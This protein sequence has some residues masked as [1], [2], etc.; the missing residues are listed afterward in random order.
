MRKHLLFAFIANVFFC[1]FSV[2]AQT[3][4]PLKLQYDFP[5]TLWESEALP[6]GNGNIGA[7]VFGDVPTDIIQINEHSLWSGGPGKNPNY[8]GGHLQTPE[9][10]TKNLLRAQEAL[11]KDMTAFSATKQAYID[12]SGKVVAQN[13]PD[14]ATTRAY[15]N[16]LKGTKNDFGSYQSLGNINIAYTS[17]VIPEILNITGDCDNPIGGEKLTLLFDGSIN[18]KWY[19]DTGFKKFPCYV[20]WEYASPFATSAYTLTSGNDVPDRDP[21]SWNLYGSNDGQEYTLID[22][23]SNITFSGRNQS[24]RYALSSTVIYKY[25]KFEILATAGS[26]GTTPPQLSEIALENAA[27]T[28]FPA[29][30]NY[31]RELDIDRSVA[32]V[33][34]TQAGVNYTREYFISH[35]NNVLV[36]RLTADQ[37]GKLS[38]NIWL[39]T[40]QTKVSISASAPEGT[41]TYGTVAITGQ[42]SD[43]TANGLKFA[44]E[45]QV[46]APNGTLSASNDKLTVENADEILII[47]SAATNYFWCMDDTYNYFSTEDPLTKAEVS[48]GK[49]SS[50]AYSEILDKHIQDYQSLFNRMSLSLTNAANTNGKMTDK[51]LAGYKNGTNTTS[52]NLYLEELYFQYGRYL[53]ISS[54]RKGSLPA[55]LQGIWAEGLTPP[56][57]AD[58]HTNINIQMNYWLAEQTNLADCH[59]PAIDYV[60]S[61]VPRG[62]FTAKRYF[63]EKTRGW[64]DFHENN[65]WGNTGPATSDAFYFPAAAGWLC[66]DIWEYYL[67][68]QDKEFLAEY[69][70]VMLDAALFWVDNLWTDTRDGTLVASPSYSPEHGPYAIGTACDQGVIT[71]LFDM[72]IKA[73]YAITSQ[74]VDAVPTDPNIVEIQAAKARLAG[75]Q[76]GL[77]GQFMEWKDETQLDISGDGGHRHANHLFWL[78]PGSQ[79]VAGRSAQE[80]LYAEAMKKSLNTRGDG[81]TGWSKAWKINFWARL[82]DGNHSHKMVQELLKE[83]TLTNLFDTHPPF[84]IDGNFGATAGMTEMLV[85]S[86]GDAIEILPALSDNWAS[87]SFK[88][89]KARGNFELSADWTNKQLDKLEITSNSGKKCI[90]KYPGIKDYTV[91]GVSSTV[92]DD[93]T[94]SFN[95]T[96][97]TVY[98]ISK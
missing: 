43:Q 86:Q 72:V 12:E 21:K 71:E 49:V 63:G 59:W 95:T 33:T 66:Q 1:S 16:Q 2:Q 36:I 25:F 77:A 38:R 48:I 76:I 74:T 15:V 75:P 89:V 26:N 60:K 80:D 79:I 81:G 3:T 20:A 37:P 47:S 13:Y 29:F 55:N 51:L 28:Q 45:L 54:S 65:I 27:A 7:M 53:L 61:L 52:E 94:I 4:L 69:Y 88:G 64:V 22:T 68:N 91:T 62:K 5:A 44:Q 41:K 19:S 17:V 32:K 98:T 67:F 83:S 35:P 9:A 56:W 84:Q 73:Y 18:T 90:I 39:T 97:G 42:P 70:P 46:F 24:I 96:E 11:Q 57:A 34:Y 82:R 14:N 30:T 78:H 6:L 93:N 23:R 85:Q 31:R 87:G 8:N 10:N 50:E 58:Y 40:P 92:I